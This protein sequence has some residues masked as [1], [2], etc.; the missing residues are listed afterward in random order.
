MD[1]EKPHEC[2]VVINPEDFEKIANY[3]I[4]TPVPF[5]RIQQANEV[6]QILLKKTQTMNIRYDD[7]KIEDNGSK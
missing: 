1:T 5:G 7:P 4:E 3:I 6:K 2:K